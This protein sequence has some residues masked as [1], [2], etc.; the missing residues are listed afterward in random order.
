MKWLN[1]IVRVIQEKFPDGELVVSSGVSPSGKYHLGTLREVLTAEVVSYALN[2]AGRKARHIHIVDDLDPFR[3]LP[4]GIPEHYSEYLGLP[5]CDIPSPT[6]KNQ[7]YADYYLEDLLNAVKVLK[8]DVE[9]IRAHEKYRSGY[10]TNAIEITLENINEVKA[11]LEKV[12]GHKI[13]KEWSPVQVIEDGYLK[14]REIVSIDKKQKTVTYVSGAN[15]KQNARYDRGEVKLNWRIDWP[16][17]WSLLGVNAEPFGRDH[18]TKGG[19]YDTGELIVKDI[20]N[21]SPPVPIP[22][23]FVNRSGETKKMSKSA[24]N[25]VTLSELLMVLP[26]EVVWYFIVRYAPEKQ[27]FFDESNTLIKLIDDFSTLLSKK[28]KSE[29]DK[30]LIDICLHNGIQP[31][32]SQIPF[33]HLVACYQA[34]LEDPDKTID[35]ISRSEYKSVA[36]K[37]RA[38]IIAELNYIKEWLKNWAP[39]EVK[40]HLSEHLN[41]N[42]FNDKQKDLL[43]K[44]GENITQAPTDADGNWFHEA[45][46]SAI[47]SVEI[48]PSEA[49]KTIYLAVINKNFGPRAGW[50]LSILPRGWLIKRLKLEA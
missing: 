33:S 27:L 28:D 5:L 41:V 18:A 47:K 49:F 34:S 24:G 11:I 50:F 7:S 17:R 20:F 32:I 42:D 22:Y 14:N 10:F 48:T 26:A 38:I 43:T 9:I 29:E 4:A 45:I 25:V 12:S 37:E 19:S 36:L 35:V 3:K 30:Q 16:A 31:T 23:D 15:H 44:L 6:D 40:F 39:E 8:L 21:A 1:D 46:Y 2:N 13:G